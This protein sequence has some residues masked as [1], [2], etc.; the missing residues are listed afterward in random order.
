ME[1]SETS[2]FL[3]NG[4]HHKSENFQIKEFQSYLSDGTQKVTSVL[5]LDEV[6]CLALSRCVLLI[7]VS[8]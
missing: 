6:I 4:N 5:L 7:S 2:C 3:E 8:P 1:E